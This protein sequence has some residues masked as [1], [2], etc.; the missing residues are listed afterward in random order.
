MSISNTSDLGF[1]AF[2]E[3]NGHKQCSE[4]SIRKNK[5]CFSFNISQESMSALYGEFI[6][7]DYYKYNAIVRQLRKIISNKKLAE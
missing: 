2:L 7:S 4:P 1:V 5:Y 6:K 3:L